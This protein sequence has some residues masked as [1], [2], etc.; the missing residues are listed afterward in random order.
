[1]TDRSL[2]DFAVVVPMANEEDMFDPFIAARS[3][4]R[5]RLGSDKVSFVVDNVSRKRV[6]GQSV[7][8]GLH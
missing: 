3:M 6:H 1:M 8:I 4:V 7:A 2:P 5:D